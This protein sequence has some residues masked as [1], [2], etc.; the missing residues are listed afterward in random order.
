MQLVVR[1]IGQ[2]LGLGHLE[3]LDGP[4]VLPLLRVEMGEPQEVGGVDGV[5]PEALAQDVAQAPGAA[6]A[7]VLL[8]ALADLGQTQ[9]DA[10]VLGVQPQSQEEEVR[11]LL[12]PPALGEAPREIRQLLDL[13]RGG[14]L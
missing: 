11:R 1:R 8:L 13:A 14:A 10:Q 9:L 7:P 5:A 4:G 3:A 6:A 12:V 2:I